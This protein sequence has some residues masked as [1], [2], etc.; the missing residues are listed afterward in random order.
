ML[1]RSRSQITMG[2]LDSP[3][4]LHDK[5]DA[6]T[7]SQPTATHPGTVRSK[8][9]PRQAPSGTAA[10]PALCSS[11]IPQPSPQQLVG[12]AG[13][14]S[15]IFFH[16]PQDLHQP[17]LEVRMMCRLCGRARALDSKHHMTCQ[18]VDRTFAGG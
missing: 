1:V 10:L 11:S 15:Q 17:L 12:L 9:C 3:D 18:A 2:T 13:S 8:S 16:I 5:A 14:A 6:A 4:A 7:S